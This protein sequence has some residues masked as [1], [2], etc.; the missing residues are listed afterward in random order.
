MRGVKGTSK[1]ETKRDYRNEYRRRKYNE[2]KQPS[3]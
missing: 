3:N 2:Q 1:G